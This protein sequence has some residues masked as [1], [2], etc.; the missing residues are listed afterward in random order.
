MSNDNKESS[1]SYAQAMEQIQEI[2]RAINE[3]NMDVD[4]LGERVAR[5][6][7]LIA[8]CRAKLQKASLQIE[9]A[10]GGTDG[11]ASTSSS[12]NYASE[13]NF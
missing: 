1:L 4:L 13:G 8:M 6:T 12:E 9:Q 2:L 10:V 11:S 5:A 7:G 3:N